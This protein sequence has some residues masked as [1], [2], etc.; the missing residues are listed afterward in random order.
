MSEVTKSSEWNSK[1]S[2]T[3]R[4]PVKTN[5]YH[6]I[7]YFPRLFLKN[8]EKSFKKLF[9][10]EEEEENFAPTDIDDDDNSDNTKSFCEEADEEVYDLCSVC[11][12]IP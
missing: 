4:T 2:D 10:F 7:I 5:K 12:E 8:S 11:D 9:G 3:F 6:G 1:Q